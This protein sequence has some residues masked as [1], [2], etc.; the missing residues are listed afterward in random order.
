MANRDSGTVVRQFPKVLTE[1]SNRS[2]NLRGHRTATSNA[3]EKM[4]S[5]LTVRMVRSAGSSSRL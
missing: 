1:P 2:M 4:A 3:D 5:L